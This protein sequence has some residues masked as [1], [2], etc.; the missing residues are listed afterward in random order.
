MKHLIGLDKI[1]GK[2]YV[3]FVT[4]DSPAFEA[5]KRMIR[6]PWRPGEVIPVTKEELKSLREDLLSVRV[7]GD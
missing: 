1:M 7:E 5:V 3:F 2:S 6:T 4:R